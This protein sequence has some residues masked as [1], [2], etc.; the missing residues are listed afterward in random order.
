MPTGN[1]L[2]EGQRE[3]G[4]SPRGEPRKS[5]EK[6]QPSIHRGKE[7]HVEKVIRV[8]RG[9]PGPAGDRTSPSG[10]RLAWDSERVIVAKKPGNAGGAK[11]PNFRGADRRSQRIGD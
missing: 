9:S 3:A 4:K 10:R 7:R 11:D 2:R 6:Y 1:W 5:T 8:R